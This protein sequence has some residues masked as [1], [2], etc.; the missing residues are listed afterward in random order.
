[1]KGKPTVK[2]RAD[3]SSASQAK[4]QEENCLPAAQPAFRLRNAMYREGLAEEIADRF[5]ELTAPVKFEE[6]AG[7][8]REVSAILA[9]QMRNRKVQ[10]KQGKAAY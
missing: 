8:S 4:G 6:A 5:M 9:R 7:L 2:E 10:P 3:P 1:M